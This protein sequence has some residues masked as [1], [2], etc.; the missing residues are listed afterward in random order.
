MSVG[1][2][3]GGGD[4]LVV[5]QAQT[6][7]SSLVRSV[8][9]VRFD[10]RLRDWWFRLAARRP[11]GRNFR[12]LMPR[13]RDVLVGIFQAFA[14]LFWR[15]QIAA[16]D[17]ANLATLAR[18]I[19]AKIPPAP[20]GSNPH[21]SFI[22][23]VHEQVRF[24]LACLDSIAQ[25][26]TDHTYE[27]LVGD[28]ASM[29]ETSAALQMIPAVRRITHARRLG[30]VENC[31]AL[32]SY[33]RGRYIAILNNDVV[34]FPDWLESMLDTFLIVPKTGLAGGMLLYPD[35]RL[36][37]AGCE[38]SSTADIRRIGVGGSTNNSAFQKMGDVDYCSGAALILPAALWRQLGG[39]D[40]AF[41][42]AYYED[43]DLAFRVRKSGRSVV[44]Q[45]AAKAFHFLGQT[46]QQVFFRE[47]LKA[48]IAE[49]RQKF[50]D[51]WGSE[52]LQNRE[53]AG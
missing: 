34:L 9:D 8:N 50:I 32:G 25:Q 51:R 44:Y 4:V 45:P 52:L 41:A 26:R 16:F 19:A 42:P 47:D 1:G 12:G 35:G 30:F 2:A 27:I 15:R 11:R 37:E 40:P 48:L 46:Q 33:A 5:T 21:V 39:F 17:P 6:H 36:Q 10:K 20:E 3:S 13:D 31:N 28:D 49:N 29:D 22:V 43:A 18:A 23:P 38:V 24:T 7:G 53:F 14:F